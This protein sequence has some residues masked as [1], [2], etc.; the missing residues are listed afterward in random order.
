MEADKSNKNP[1]K[2]THILGQPK[3]ISYEKKII[4][5][6]IDGW[7]GQVNYSSFQVHAYPIL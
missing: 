5:G 4:E 7:D 2:I 1:P 3:M 6:L